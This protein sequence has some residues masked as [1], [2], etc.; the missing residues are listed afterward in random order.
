MG[1]AWSSKAARISTKAATSR[2]S[3]APKASRPM[4]AA[5]IVLIAEAVAA[6]A[7][8]AE[9]TAVVVADVIVAAAVGDA[10]V[11]PGAVEAIATGNP[12]ARDKR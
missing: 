11:V 10:V 12:G 8:D 6:I 5:A 4:W 7:A 3:T 1:T 2:I 9:A